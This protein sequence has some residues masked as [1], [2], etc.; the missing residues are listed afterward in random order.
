ML[1]KVRVL[2]NDAN[3]Q[4]EKGHRKGELRDYK[5]LSSFESEKW[6]SLD[7]AKKLLAS[8]VEEL[9]SKWKGSGNI[10]VTSLLTDGC[11]TKDLASEVL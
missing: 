6:F 3:S 8:K 11:E 4:K 9:R 10:L 2:V 7:E 5:N 1:Y